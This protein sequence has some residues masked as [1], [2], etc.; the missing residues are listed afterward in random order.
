MAHANNTNRSSCIF[1]PLRRVYVSDIFPKPFSKIVTTSFDRTEEDEQQHISV[2]LLTQ[3][4]VNRC[5]NQI[6]SNNNRI[7][8]IALLRIVACV[9]DGNCCKPKNAPGSNYESNG[10]FPF[11]EKR[12][13]HIFSRRSTAPPVF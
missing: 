3:K 5:G 12:V 4:N 7:L 9:I 2:R 13:S 11:L 8:K 1:S 10:N 6:N